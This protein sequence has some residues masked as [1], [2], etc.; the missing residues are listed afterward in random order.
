[1]DVE[2]GYQCQKTSNINIM[3]WVKKFEMPFVKFTTVCLSFILNTKLLP[4]SSRRVAISTF[5]RTFH[6]NLKICPAWWGW[7]CTA[8]PPPFTASPSLTKLR[9]V[10]ILPAYVLCVCYRNYLLVICNLG[11]D[12]STSNVSSL[13][14][15]KRQVLWIRND[16]VEI[17]ILLFR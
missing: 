2:M 13:N 10:S 9:C 12:D 17:R 7:G 16:L 6:Y 15:L 5:W 11:E 3:H 14:L 4:Q 1:M 8:R